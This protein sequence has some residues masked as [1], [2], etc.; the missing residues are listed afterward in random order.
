MLSIPAMLALASV[1]SLNI[2]DT[3]MIGRLGVEPLAARAVGA[4]L[5]GGIYWIFAFLTFGTTTLVGHYHGSRDF[6]ACCA[7]FV[8]SLVL[9]LLGG[10]GVSLAGLFLAPN[11]YRLMGATPGVIDAGIPYFR[12][13]ITSAPFTFVFCASVG[14]FR[15]VQDTKTP[16]LIAFLA[17]GLNLVLD[18]V[19]I[20]GGFGILPMG[21]KGTLL[22]PGSLSSSGQPSV[23][24]FS[25]V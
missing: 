13:I 11:L 19:L 14:L 20:Y 18:Y 8:H 23:F 6:E 3:A 16:M 5:I 24:L 25:F 7:T 9:A 12:L 17:N 22:P 10:L 4:A 15:G 2:G 21:L 1:P